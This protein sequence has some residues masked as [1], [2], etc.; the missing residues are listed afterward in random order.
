MTSPWPIGGPDAHDAL[1]DLSNAPLA[2][3][4]TLSI[5]PLDADP[6]LGWIEQVDGRGVFLRRTE[7]G[8][9]DTTEPDACSKPFRSVQSVPG[10]A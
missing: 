5:A 10:P 6:P 7:T 8:P 2:E 9:E 3:L 1:A 4:G